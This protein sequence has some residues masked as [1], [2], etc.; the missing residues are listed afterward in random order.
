MPPTQNYLIV[1]KSDA[2]KTYLLFQLLGAKSPAPIVTKGFNNHIV[3]FNDHECFE[4]WDPSGVDGQREFWKSIYTNVIFDVIIYVIDALKYARA[5]NEEKKSSVL[6]D[7]RMELHSLLCDDELR[8]TKFFLYL[9][10]RQ[11]SD[12]APH[13]RERYMEEIKD[14]L[15]MFQ[16]QDKNPDFSRDAPKEDEKRHYK[17][18]DSVIAVGSYEDL[19]DAIGLNPQ[20]DATNALL[21]VSPTQQAMTLQGDKKDKTVKKGK[22]GAKKG[23]NRTTTSNAPKGAKKGGK[24]PNNASVDNFIFT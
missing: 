1:G 2:G 10:W 23:V 8:N 12:I 14:E 7:D 24:R 20:T 13:E 19:I 5:Q 9:N 15:E 4:V 3:T 18:M 22:K 11:D 21:N 17:H 16:F 6:L